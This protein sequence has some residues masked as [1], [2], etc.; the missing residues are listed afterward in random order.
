M[1]EFYKLLLV[2]TVLLSVLLCVV[3]SGTAMWHTAYGDLKGMLHLTHETVKDGTQI[4]TNQCRKAEDA[5]KTAAAAAAKTAAAK[6]AAAAAAA[7]AAKTAANAAKP[8]AVVKETGVQDPVPADM[9]SSHDG[10]LLY[11]I[12]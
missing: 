9:G 3:I 5:A 11:G 12:M 4:T 7:A 2:N 10:K 8:P 6:T 1:L